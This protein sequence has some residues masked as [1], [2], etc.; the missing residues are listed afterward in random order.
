MNDERLK[1]KLADFAKL[2]LAHDGLWFQAVENKYGIEVAIELDGVAWSKFSPI[3]AKRIMNRCGLK[4]GGGIDS[5]LKALPERLY[6][7]LNKQEVL[8]ADDKHAVF[9]MKTCRVQDARHKKN[10]K[11]FPCKEVGIIEY[12]EFAKTIDP[13]IQ[14][15]CLHCPPD[16]YNGQFW[17]KWEFSIA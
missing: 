12:S 3:E 9:V 5:L 11:P 14:T 17:C 6:G 4:P 1:N 16:K 2:W 13:R 7:L 10:L 8:E 15:K